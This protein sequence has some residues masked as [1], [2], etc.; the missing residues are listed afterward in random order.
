[1]I[2]NQ[3]GMFNVNNLDDLCTTLF[4]VPVL[5]DGLLLQEVVAELV[6]LKHYPQLC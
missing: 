1:M 5:F 2:E 4:Y 3:T 6:T